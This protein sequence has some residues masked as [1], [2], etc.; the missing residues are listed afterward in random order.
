MRSDAETVEAVLAGQREAFADLVRRYEGTVHAVAMGVLRDHHAAQDVC[1][2]TFVAAYKS[3]ATLREPSSF[4]SWIMR[5][6]RNH[7]LSL[8]RQ[9]PPEQPLGESPEIP[10]HQGNGRLDERSQRLLAVVMELREHERTL[11]MLKYFAGYSLEQLSEMT[12]RPV[13]TVGVQ[14]YRARAHLRERLEEVEP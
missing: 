3:L 6:A 11:V 10:C 7:A 8:V 5:M 9:R 1:Q 13:G 12:G 14:L 4:G 2:E